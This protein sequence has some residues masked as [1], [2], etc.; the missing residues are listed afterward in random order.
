MSLLITSVSVIQP[1]NTFPDPFLY[2][3]DDPK[4]TL[5]WSIYSQCTSA[6]YFLIENTFQSFDIVCRIT[7]FDE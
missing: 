2:L 1:V 5:S 3:S 6:V 7:D 4:D